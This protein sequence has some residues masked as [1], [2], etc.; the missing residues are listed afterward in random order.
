M[1]MVFADQYVSMFIETG[2]EKDL[3]GLIENKRGKHVGVLEQILAKWVEQLEGDFANEA[4]ITDDEPEV[5]THPFST[6]LQ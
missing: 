6:R 4:D 5:I 1:R 3:D 2:S